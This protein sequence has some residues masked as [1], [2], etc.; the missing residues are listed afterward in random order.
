MHPALKQGWLGAALALAG[1]LALALAFPDWEQPFLSAAALV[2]LGY[3]LEALIGPGTPHAIRRAF[4]RGWIF[5]LGLFGL[6]LHWI[7]RLPLKELTQPWLLYPALVVLMAYLA[8]FTGGVG[9]SYVLLRRARVPAA[10]ALPIAWLGWEQ[11]RAMGEMGFPWL[12][13]GYAWFRHPALIQWAAWGGIG[14]VSLWVAACNGLLLQALLTPNR[15]AR[16]ALSLA[17]P[18][19]A[20]VVALTGAATVRDLPAGRS[21]RVAIVQPNIAGDIKWDP[22]YL[23]ANLNATVALTGTVAARRPELIVWPETAVPT[24]LRYDDRAFTQVTGLVARLGIPLLTGFPD[25]RP[26]AVAGRAIFNSSSVVV[27]PGQLDGFYDKM[28]LVPF[29][30]RIPFQRFLP[31]LGK[32]ELGQ[33]EWMPGEHA[34]ALN[35]GP[36]RAGVMICFE[37]IFTD[38]ARAEVRDGADLLVNITNDEWFGPRT[39]PWQHASMAV[40]RA[41]ENRT[42]LVRCANTGVS[43]LVDPDGSIRAATPVFRA[44]TVVED[45]RLGSGG[46]FYT[47]HGDWLPRAWMTLCVAQLAWCAVASLLTRGRRR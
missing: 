47:R 46:T 4:G 42:G 10:V 14:A 30:E 32:F 28:H 37:S 2:P 16:A 45:A 41:V 3:A 11:I 38:I 26:D 18:V 43:F 5:G 19:L 25:A 36:A 7:A 34:R 35:A 33:A 13:L 12:S 39:A 23:V 17:P 9:V 31:F 20:T 6:G 8:L 24:Y 27:P 21:L 29:G 15:A 44:A 40:F 22:R 1:G